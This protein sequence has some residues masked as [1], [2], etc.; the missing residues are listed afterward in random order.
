MHECG[1][2]KNISKR[3]PNQLLKFLTACPLHELV[4]MFMKLH[5]FGSKLTTLFASGISRICLHFV[6]FVTA[7]KIRKISM[8]L[9]IF[10][11]ICYS[12][13]FAM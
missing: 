1:L 7:N 12:C 11:G 2:L 6:A 3:E 10:Q 5:Y 8:L 13:T 9:L 4:D